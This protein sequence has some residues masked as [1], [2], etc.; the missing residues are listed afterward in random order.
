MLDAATRAPGGLARSLVAAAFGAAGTVIGGMLGLLWGF[1]NQDGLVQ[2]VVVGAVTGALVSVELAD[3]LLRIW[4]CG[5]CSM[6]GR[7]KRTRL[8]LR[9]VAAGRLLRGSVFPAISGALDSQIEAL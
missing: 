7:I 3:S 5:D 4:T 8:V 1:V 9:S 6:D 2:G